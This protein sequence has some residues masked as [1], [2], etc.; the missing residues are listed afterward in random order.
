MKALKISL[1]AV[2]L[3]LPFFVQKTIAQSDFE[4]KLGRDYYYIDD[5]NG[6]MMA[7]VISG[8]IS[9]G[10]EIEAVY[11][12]SRT[13]MKVV[14][15]KND[16]DEKV[17][18]AKAGEKIML[19]VQTSKENKIPNSFNGEQYNIVPKGKKVTAS[20]SNITSNEAVCKAKLTIDGSIW[21]SNAC[22]LQFWKKG[23]SVLKINQPFIQIKF[24]KENAQMASGSEIFML[25]LFSPMPND[26]SKIYN[27]KSMEISFQGYINGK[28]VYYGYALKGGKN[29]NISLQISSYTE[30]NNVAKIT[31]KLSGKLN[32]ILC[33]ECK[34]DVDFSLDF[35]GTAMRI[36]SER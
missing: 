3:C 9:L 32:G 5:Q 13:A 25:Y 34:P 24:S 14:E 35:E 6:Y 8:S 21:E 11:A 19:F 36:F 33:P 10:Q 15:I 29:Q 20:T 4:L 18:I 28:Q 12:D 31:G 2:L 27:Q 17:T 1:L 30:A 22:D 7:T 23:N 16:N 26:K